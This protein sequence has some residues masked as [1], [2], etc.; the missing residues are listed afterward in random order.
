MVCAC[1]LAAF[2]AGVTA[3]QVA[4]PRAAPALTVPVDGGGA[5]DLALPPPGLR[6]ADPTAEPV[7][8]ATTPVSA[9]ATGRLVLAARTS[10]GGRIPARMLEAYRSAAAAMAVSDPGCHLDWSLLAGIGKV[11]S[12]HARGGAVTADGRTVS[13]ILG[14]VLSGG[15]GVAAIH[16]TDGGRYDG[17][18]VWDRAVGPMQFIPSSWALFG[19]DGNRDGVSDPHNVDDATLAAAAYLCRGGGD[20]RDPQDVARAV[21]GYNH[22][23]DYVAA[24]LAWASAYAHGGVLVVPAV[25]TTPRAGGAPT[26]LAAA[27]SPTASAA[28]G[29][30][31]GPT[32]TGKPSAASSPTA[33]GGPSPSA[34]E[35]TT[36]S[37]PTVDA[38]P[39]SPT[40]A[41]SD[42]AAS[43]SPT[44]S[45]TPTCPTGS[46]TPTPTASPS[47]TPSPSDDPCATPT[48][49]P[50]TTAAAAA[51]PTPTPTP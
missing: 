9:L 24:V 15:P 51:E 4:G 27:S 48:P 8:V 7:A 17:D 21:F 38:S 37:T 26:V 43:P 44:P 36:G 12:G 45:P 34:V 10:A 22:S 6:V 30:P 50:T 33:S 46:P 31:S 25:A 16:D 40:T 41:P 2:G 23:W 32:A 1:L 11:E 13:A 47:P 18:V 35:G 39:S 42:G 29:V 3:D 14:P 19:R 5:A 28:P 20:L 49:S